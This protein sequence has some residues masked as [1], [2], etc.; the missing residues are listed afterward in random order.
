MKGGKNCSLA[1][2]LKVR[3]SVFLKPLIALISASCFVFKPPK[4][5]EVP[6][7]VE[8][9]PVVAEPFDYKAFAEGYPF[10]EEGWE[11]GRG[12]FIDPALL[13]EVPMLWEP[14]Q[15][16]DGGMYGADWRE[17]LFRGDEEVVV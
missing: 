12:Q 6:A 10:G 5:P 7:Q 16:Q 17:N 1:Y 14:G 2:K 8:E 13:G 4:V 3:R 15:G 11:G 9:P